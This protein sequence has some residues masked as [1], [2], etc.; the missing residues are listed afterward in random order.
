[1]KIA[2]IFY[3]N[4]S[5][6]GG[7]S[8][9]LDCFYK[10][11][12]KKN[13][14][15]YFFNPYYKN[16]YTL[17]MLK[18][19]R[20]NFKEI[21]PILV[22]IEFYKILFLS[23]WKIIWDKKVKISNRIMILLYI[24]IK[25]D[26]FFNT[27]ANTIFLHPYFKKIN[28]D[29]IVGGTSSG[30]TLTLIFLLSRLFNKKNISFT[31][32]NEFLIHKRFSLKTYYFRSIDLLL[33]GTYRLQNLLKKIHHLNDKQLKVLRYGLINEHY[34]I[35]ESKEELRI[36]YNIPQDQFVLLSVGRHVARKRFGLVI[37]ALH[38]IKEK[39]P[40]IDIK[41]YLIGEGEETPN[42]KNLTNSLKLEE[43]VEFL[44]YTDITTRNQFYKLSDLFL[45][46]STEEKESIEGFGIV[47]LEANYFKLPVIGSFS[48][49]MVE[50]IIDGTTGLLVKPNDLIDLV[51]K[52]LFLYHNKEIRIKMGIE[53]HK[54][55]IQEFNWSKNIDDYIN[56]F[57]NILE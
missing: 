13:H 3:G 49:G 8:H 5:E 32:G 14:T 52:I 20:Y 53:G 36:S 46:P 45:M 40:E 47:F 1:M 12:K 37:E 44:G 30:E 39:L 17:P 56:V 41:Y 55:V 29:L 42:L 24:F 22:N 33:S 27:I 11:F 48:G 51:E 9:V 7:I 6:Q 4:P 2:L 16:N 34:E 38:I 31:Y 10:S 19:K 43:H 28:F 25:R 54:R 35:K 15:L 26:I 57:K 18:K 50:T 23:I 21:Y